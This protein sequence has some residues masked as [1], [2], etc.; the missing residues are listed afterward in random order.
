ML[1]FS[2]DPKTDVLIHTYKTYKLYGRIKV[3]NVEEWNKTHDKK[4]ILYRFCINER[5]EEIPDYKD[6]I[7]KLKAKERK[8]FYQQRLAQGYKTM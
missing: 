4:Y 5:S 2:S 6:V 7:E 1:G 3:K 8:E